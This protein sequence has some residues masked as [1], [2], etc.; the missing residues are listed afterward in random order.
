[1]LRLDARVRLGAFDADLAL[2]VATG[3]CLAL[4]GPSGA[5]K[6]SVL[7]IA[8]GIVR[9]DEGRVTCGD[10]VWLD[11]RRAIN[12]APE[13]RRCGYVFQDYAL[14]GHLRAWQNVAYPLR[15][16]GRRERRARAHALLERFGVGHLADARP[17]TLSG[18]ERQRVAVARALAREPRALLLDEPLSALDAEARLAVRRT[19]RRH[20]GTFAGP[21]LLVTHDPVEAAALADR[22]LVVEAGRVVQTGGLDAVTRR[23][24]SD[25][26]AGLVGVNL[27]RGRAR[28]G[29]VELASG[30]ALLAAAPAEGDVFAVIHPRAV[31]LHR[32]RPEGTPRNVW[33]GT[34]DGLE[35]HGDRVRVD[36]AGPVHVVAAV[37]PAAVAALDLGRGGTV[38]VSVKASEVD[39]YPA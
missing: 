12:V 15:G 20:L 6:T 14:F 31:A 13:H 29:R 30:H 1:M 35:T 39:L 26:V 27:Y 8:A 5:G 25:W 22:L 24:R 4:A 19:L 37:T 38:W 3:A 21:C 9:P 33:A 32:R 18:G 36:V 7:R 28:R 11:T 34:V 2:E 17:R 16:L 10:E 23:P